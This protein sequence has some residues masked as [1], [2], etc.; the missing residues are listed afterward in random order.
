VAGGQSVTING[1]NLDEI[2]EVTFGGTQATITGSN[3][4]SV[5]VVTPAHAAG[6]VSITVTTAGGS[7]T[8]ANAYTYLNAPVVTSLSKRKGSKKGGE[9]VT[10][11]G[12]YLSNAVS[13]SF[14]GSYASILQN[15]NSSIR[16]STPAHAPGEVDVTV[17][18][19]GGSTTV[20]RAY[21]FK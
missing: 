15:T 21:Q 12:S 11:S 2:V 19:R 6:V 18:T 20:M 7:A 1:T 17:T 9:Q 16:V 3:G 8:L 14:G 5:T 13:V 10:I 4:S